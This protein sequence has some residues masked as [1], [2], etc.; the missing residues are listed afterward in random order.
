ML[1]TVRL[2]EGLRRLVSRRDPPEKFGG[3]P[4]EHSGYCLL[5]EELGLSDSSVR[6]IVS[7]SLG[8]FGKTV[9][10]EGTDEQRAE[11]LPGICSGAHLGCF[12]PTEPRSRQRR[13]PPHHEYPVGKYLRDARVATLYEGTTQIQKL[14]IG[15]ALTGVSA[16]SLIGPGVARVA[17][18]V[19]KRLTSSATQHGFTPPLSSTS[20]WVTTWRPPGTSS[21]V[22]SRARARTSAWLGSGAGKR[23]RL[24]P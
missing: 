12:A 23:T 10:E 14:T 19:R 13:R 7:V 24:A 5:M 11:W 21:A 8:F 22:S 2:W 15:Q 16:F 20:T 6:G 17:G 1:W 3:T 4:V 9:H 18:Q